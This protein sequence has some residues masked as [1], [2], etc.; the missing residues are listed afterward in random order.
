MSRKSLTP[1]VS[2]VVPAYGHADYIL[3]SL[4]SVFAQTFRDFEVIV[5]NDGSP[6]DTAEILKP[7]IVSGKIKYFEQENS[8][9]A[10]ARNLGIAHSNSKY[11]ALLDDD[12]L[13]PT[14]KLEWQV[15]MMEL[16]GA[17][18]IGGCAGSVGPN[19]ILVDS[20]E[21]MGEPRR[22]AFEEFFDG[23]PFVSPGQVLIDRMAIVEIGGFDPEVWGA[24]DFDVYMSLSRLGPILKAPNLGLYYRIHHSNA[25]HNHLKMILNTKRVLTKQL[26]RLDGLEKMRC[27]RR[28][29]QWM[30]QY[31]GATMIL[32]I[33]RSLRNPGRD[34]RKGFANAWTFT[35][36]F[37]WQMLIDPKM[38]RRVIGFVLRMI[39][40]LSVNS[41]TLKSK[42]L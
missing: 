4:D 3:D 34:F 31:L 37:G 7:L 5:V 2:V 6:D 14:D 10:V 40:A 18:A 41:V 21:G 38:F 25:S 30:F 12:D 29:Y 15:K 20:T 1:L 13:W 8:G 11:I 17:I 16:T 33:Q 27:R 28:G 9:V 32:E 22:I 39:P 19:G 42:S 23:N 35:R 36:V 24:D 26:S